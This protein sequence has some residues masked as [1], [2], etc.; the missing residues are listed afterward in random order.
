MPGT[1]GI[2]PGSHI[3]GLIFLLD[4]PVLQAVSKHRSGVSPSTHAGV[5]TVPGFSCPAPLPPLSSFGGICPP[6]ES[7]WSCPH[8]SEQAEVLA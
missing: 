6:G 5:S 4:H 1:A 2:H 3:P 7:E 8:S